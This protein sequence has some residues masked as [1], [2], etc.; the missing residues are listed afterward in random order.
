[1]HNELHM[2]TLLFKLRKTPPL[3]QGL[4]ITQVFWLLGLVTTWL[5]LTLVSLP[6]PLSW[7]FVA[8]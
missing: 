3:T 2:V 1:M 5:I 8:A 4:F 7:L 6:L